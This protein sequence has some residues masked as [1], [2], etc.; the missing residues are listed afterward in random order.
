MEIFADGISNASCSVIA[1]ELI[2][3]EF[4]ISSTYFFTPKIVLESFVSS[5]VPRIEFLALSVY[6]LREE[7]DSPLS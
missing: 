5:S 1:T 3:E 2:L 4:T 7:I 6:N